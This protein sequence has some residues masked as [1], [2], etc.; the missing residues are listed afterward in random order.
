MALRIASSS[1]VELRDGVSRET[2]PVHLARSCGACT[3]RRRAA[4]HGT[5]PPFKSASR[6]PTTDFHSV[7]CTAG[8]RGLPAPERGH[9]RRNLLLDRMRE[10]CY[11]HIGRHRNSRPVQMINKRWSDTSSCLPSPFDSSSQRTIL[12]FATHA[13]TRSPTLLQTFLTRKNAV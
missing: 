9:S 5:Q 7:D 11:W 12:P 13:S 3:G 8:R 1:G 10:H 6:R 4:G 2:P